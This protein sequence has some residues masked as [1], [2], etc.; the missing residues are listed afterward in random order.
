MIVDYDSIVIDPRFKGFY[1]GLNRKLQ[2]RFLGFHPT[3]VNG[4][5]DVIYE[6]T[7]ETEYKLEDLP[8]DDPLREEVGEVFRSDFPVI[9]RSQSDW[10]NVVRISMTS[11]LG[12]A[13]A[14]PGIGFATAVSRIK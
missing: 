9:K 11:L 3:V 5:K 8:K 6:P 10:T 1:L 2:A 13:I 4:K 7:I 14:I 12:L